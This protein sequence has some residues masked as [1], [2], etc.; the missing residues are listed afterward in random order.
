MLPEYP[1]KWQF[2]TSHTALHN[3][4]AEGNLSGVQRAA[5]WKLPLGAGVWHVYLFGK[6]KDSEVTQ[7][8]NWFSKYLKLKWN[9]LIINLLKYKLKMK[10]SELWVHLAAKKCIPSDK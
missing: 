8:E 4:S 9:I 7:I 3:I 1:G 6:Q 5:F 10:L 2:Y